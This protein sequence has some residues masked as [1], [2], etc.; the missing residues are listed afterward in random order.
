MDEPFSALDAMT[1]EHLQAQLIRDRTE[2]PLPYVL[3]THSIEEAAFL[4]KTILLLADSPATIKAR[5]DNPGF[6]DPNFRESDRY[7]ELVR[8]IRRGMGA[9]F[10]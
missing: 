2:S 10:A 9:H 5:F 8:N 7:F 1:R 3:V 6:G 4:G